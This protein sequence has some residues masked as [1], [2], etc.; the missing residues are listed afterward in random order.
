MKLRRDSNRLQ[1]YDYSLPGAYFV[2]LV[3]KN[4]EAIFG[5]LVGEQ[6]VLHEAG[7]IVVEEWRK[8][9]D[10]RSDVSLD[11]FVV[12][13][14]HFHA[15]LLLQGKPLASDG[16]PNRNS[17]GAHRGAPLHNSRLRREPNSLGSIIAGFKSKVS[18]RIGRSVWQR[19]YFDRIIRDESELNKF[20]EY[21]L[22]NPL[23][24]SQEAGQ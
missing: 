3:S 16:S 11:E 9:S 13:P 22:Y 6:I 12:M 1:G 19:N 4:R 18:Q 15:I 2:T 23:L 8:T 10:L 17:L 24:L 5:R 7:Q 20:R 21:I 14:D